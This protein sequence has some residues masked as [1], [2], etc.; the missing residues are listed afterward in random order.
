MRPGK[1]RFA[2]ALLV[3]A[4]MLGETA[5]ALAAGKA[6]VVPKTGNY[7]GFA[8]ASDIGFKVTAK[9]TK[10]VDLSTHFEATVN[11]GPPAENPPLVHFPS[12]AVVKGSFHGSTSVTYGGGINPQYSIRGTFSSSTRAG[13]TISVHFDFPHN[14]LPPCNETSQISLTRA[15]K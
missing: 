9:G 8:G 5:Y 3:A 14:A 10:I 13:G 1:M 2:A 11:C 12:L 4:A 7:A 15:T 6:A